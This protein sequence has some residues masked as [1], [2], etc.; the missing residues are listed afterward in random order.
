MTWRVGGASP[1]SPPSISPHYLRRYGPNG[2]G[3]LLAEPVHPVGPSDDSRHHAPQ[4]LRGIAP[5]RISVERRSASRTAFEVG[6]AAHLAASGSLPAVA[7][8]RRHIGVVLGGREDGPGNRALICR[9]GV[10]WCADRRRKDAPAA[11]KN[12]WQSGGP[13]QAGRRRARLARERAGARG[14]C[15][16]RCLWESLSWS[17]Q[18]GCREW[19]R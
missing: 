4:G 5:S 7:Q 18:P 3:E 12:G 9:S 15:L 11:G 10:H 19:R 2:V 8:H 14:T 16:S 13:S 6:S 17:S 1:S